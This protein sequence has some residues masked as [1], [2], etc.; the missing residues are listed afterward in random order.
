MLMTTEDLLK[1]FRSLALKV[2]ARDVVVRALSI[3]LVPVRCGGGLLIEPSEDA[4]G[5]VLFL[6]RSRYLEEGRRAHRER[7]VVERT[8][9]MGRPP[10]TSATG[11]AGGGRSMLKWPTRGNTSSSLATSAV[12]QRLG[13]WDNDMMATEKLPEHGASVPSAHHPF[14]SHLHRESELHV[15]RLYRLCRIDDCS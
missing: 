8:K 2:D 9:A 7:C 1:R 10:Q 4:Q 5:D 15:S 6:L 13:H 12:R 3:V 14:S 11:T